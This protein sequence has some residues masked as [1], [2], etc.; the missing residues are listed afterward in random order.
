M[1]I[2]KD[3]AYVLRSYDFQE[4]SRIVSLFTETRGKI[5]GLCKGIRAGKKNFTTTFDIGTLNE[6]VFYESR[7]ELWLVSYA[8]FINADAAK[9]YADMEKHATLHY[10]MELVDRI[11]PLHVPAPEVFSLI[12]RALDSMQD[13]PVLYTIYIFQAKLLEMSGF[14]PSLQDCVNCG[15]AIRSC[16]F[17]SMRLGG[18]LCERCRRADLEARTVTPDVITSLQYIQH[19]DLGMAL[20]LKPSQHARRQMCRLLDEFLGYHVNARMRSLESL[21]M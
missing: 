9:F 14:R 12:E 4:T 8:D 7:N 17:F 18:M 3:R 2:V 21:C 5:R 15:A 10:I 20:R 1:A 13:R 6:V 16:A 11:M 19:H